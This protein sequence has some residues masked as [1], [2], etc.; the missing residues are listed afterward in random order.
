MT[1]RRASL[2]LPCHSWDDFPT[3]LGDQASA[4]LLAAWTSLW[5]PALIAT[6]ERM[7]GWHQAEEPPDPA[8]L[9]AELV[10]VPPPSRERMPSDWC[11]RL[12]ATAPQNPPAVETVASRQ[13]TVA[14][15]LA[16]AGIDANVVDNEVAADFF[17]LG[18]AYLQVELLTRA[19]RY[20]SVLDIEHFENAT[21]AAAKAAVAGQQDTSREELT[22]AFD[23]LADA[24]NHVYSV[25]FYVID[26]TL[27][28]ESMLGEPLRK[29]LARRSATNL[30][31][32]G[33]QIEQIAREQPD[34]LH[35]LLASLEAETVSLLGGR[36]HSGFAGSQGPEALL[37]EIN[38]GQT[39]ARTHLNR[40]YEV[41]GQ[42]D[43]A[44]SHLLP[45]AL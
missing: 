2:I 29:K 45:Q 30:L 24:R 33:S 32:A 5:H 41:Y 38:R 43:S 42:F 39:A 7:P 11:D 17:A 40:E 14:A 9:D 25:D 20:S 1:I 4:E 34:T 8:S 31:I 12:R 36:F 13:E 3:H 21:A 15:V 27:L 10:L 37:S 44:F 23:L 19:M 16:V 6:T 22:R 28:T 35:E 18:F 26:L